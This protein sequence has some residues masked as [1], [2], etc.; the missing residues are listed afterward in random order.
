MKLDLYTKV[1]LTGIAVALFYLCL[2]ETIQP[3]HA[4]AQTAR[5]TVPIV[6]DQNG[7]EAVPVIVYFDDTKS[8]LHV[9]RQKP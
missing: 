5:N 8:G 9:F 3:I 4:Q 7:Q 2:V 1:V 6:R